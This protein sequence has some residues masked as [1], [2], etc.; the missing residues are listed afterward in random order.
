MTSRSALLVGSV[1]WAA[2]AQ[3]QGHGLEVRALDERG[4][5]QAAASF[6]RTLPV[7][8]G[9]VPGPDLDARRFLLI[10][11]PDT[12]LDALEAL[13]LAPD[14]RPLD[15]LLNLPTQAATCPDGVAPELVCRVTPA[16]RLVTDALDRNHPALKRRSLRAQLGGK[17]R[18]S[19]AGRVLVELPILGPVAPP[20]RVTLRAFVLRARA[21]GEPALGGTDAAARVAVRRELAVASDLWGQCGLQLQ[22]ETTRVEVA[23]PPRGQLLAVGCGFAQPASGGWLRLQSGSKTVALQTHAG[24]SPVAIAL[25][26]ADALAIAGQAPPVFENQRTAADA[27]PSADIWLGPNRNWRAPDGESLSSDASLPIC[28]GSVDLGDGLAHFRDGDAFAGTFEERALLRAFDDGDPRTVELLVV[29]R[30]TSSQR[31][32]ESF[33]VSAGSSLSS[34]VIIDRSAVRAGA[35]SFALAHELGHVLLAMPGHPD[36]FGVDQS[37]SLMDADVADATVF[38]PRRLSLADCARAVTQSGPRALVPILQLPPSPAAAIA[39]PK[40]SRAKY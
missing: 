7:E 34:A 32:G 30:F 24:E 36:D 12:M 16:L 14:D 38:G 33:I 9:E 35:R 6:S 40:S 15:V 20:M 4:A 5:V 21:G 26:L 25:R 19:A 27:L 37:W 23:D 29:P 3:A 1:T 28:L 39:R 31:I 10:G 8:L 13:S 11:S 17:L 18:L 22:A 2:S